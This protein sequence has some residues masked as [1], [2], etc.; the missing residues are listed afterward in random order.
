MSRYQQFLVR[1][2]L[3]PDGQDLYEEWLETLDRRVADRIDAYV[4]RMESGN[5]GVTRSLGEGILELKINFGPGYRVY[6]LRDSGQ[7]VVL[8][9]GGD[10]DD[11]PGDILKARRLSADYWRR[12]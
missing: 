5:F 1:H 7:I 11:Q 6:Y 10:K 9:C 12:K 3:T 4:T 8:L 2:Y